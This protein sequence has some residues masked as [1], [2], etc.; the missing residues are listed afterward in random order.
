M[1]DTFKELERAELGARRPLARFLL[2]LAS[3]PTA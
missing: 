2:P 3:T 1:V